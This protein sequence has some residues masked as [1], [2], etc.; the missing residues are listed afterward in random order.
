MDCVIYRRAQFA[1][2]HHYWLPELSEAEN[3]AQFGK[4]ANFPGHGHN[5]VLHVGMI[6][7]VDEY[8]MVL[9]LSD[10]KQTLRSR[11]IEPLN[12]SY[13]N[14]T[15][16]EFERTLPTTECLA[17]AIW[18]RLADA[19][20]LTSVRVNEDPSLWA[21]YRGNGMKSYLTIKTH[22]SAAH[23]LAR[24]DLSFE[25]NSEIYGLCARPNGHGHNYGLEVTVVGE[26]DER[27]G[28]IVD[29]VALKE[30]VKTHVVKPFDHTF[31]NKDV[32]YFAEVVPTAENIALHIRHLLTAPLRQLGVELSKVRLQESPNNSAEVYGRIA[33]DRHC[34]IVTGRTVTGRSRTGLSS[35]TMR[36]LLTMHPLEWGGAVCGL[37]L[38]CQPMAS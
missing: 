36:P 13:L 23:R 37:G 29:L 11:V 10:V 18:H 15:W 6:G 7:S 9:N 19:L 12:F 20:P 25:E 24:P 35:L 26:M 27:T 5:Y 33:R 31:L 17:H 28:M 34:R 16:P 8:G 4:A 1:A 32:P 30:A 2:S 3:Q 14:Q 21:E 22:F 38:Y